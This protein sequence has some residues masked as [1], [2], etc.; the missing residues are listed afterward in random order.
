MYEASGGFCAQRQIST[1]AGPPFQF[2][3]STL[4]K[5]FRDFGEISVK[6]YFFHRFGLNFAFWQTTPVRINIETG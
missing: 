2:A 6:D 4:K 5:D 1:T 3:I